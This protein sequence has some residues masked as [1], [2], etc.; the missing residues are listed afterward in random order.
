MPEVS[1]DI[2]S[3]LLTIVNACEH[4]DDSIRKNRLKIWRKHEQ[5]WHGLQHLFWNE[6]DNDWATPSAGVMAEF[7]DEYGEEGPVYD[8]VINICKA[9]GESIIGAVTQRLPFVHFPP[10][11][12]NKADDI[13]TAHEFSKIAE[14]I[15]KHNPVKLLF[16][17]AWY[18]LY[19]Q[20][21]V[22]GYNYSKSDKKYGTAR[23]PKYKSKEV[24][25]TPD[26]YFCRSCGTELG[27]DSKQTCP[28][29]GDSG[30]P[31]TREG[32]TETTPTLVGYDD[33]SKSRELLDVYGP[34]HCKLPEYARDQ[35]TCGYLLFYLEQ[36]YAELKELY[37]DIADKISKFTGTSDQYGRWARSPISEANIGDYSEE[38]GLLTV[39]RGWIRPW[40]Y[41]VL[42]KTS[43]IQPKELKKEFPIGCFVTFIGDIFA[44]AHEEN[45]DDH[46]T[47][48][49]AGASSHIHADPLIQPVIPIQEMKNTLVNLTIETIEHGIPEVWGSPEVVDFDVYSQ[50]EA[51]PGM[52]NKSKTSPSGSKNLGDYFFSM[53]KATLSREVPV[54]HAR[55][56]QEAQFALGSFP[57]IFGG[58]SEGKSRTFS[59][60]SMSRAMALQRLQNPWEMMSNWWARMMDKSVRSYASHMLT[61]EQFKKRSGTNYDSVFIKMVNLQ[62]S[63]G[64]V[65][66][67]ASEDLP[68]SSAQKR[69][70]ILK[71]V[72]FNNPYINAAIYH[73]ENTKNLADALSFVDFYIPGN[74][75]RIKQ[76]I[77][78]DKMVSSNEPL[79][80]DS[81]DD[82]AVHIQVLTAILISQVGLTLRDENPEAY[83]ACIIHINEHQ[84][85]LAAKTKGQHG[86]SV[87]GEAP[88]TAAP[89]NVG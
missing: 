43:K 46:W 29:C 18:I 38:S 81:I 51:K 87:P 65:E 61:D 35:A 7:G 14:L 48:S 42:D 69:D 20:G 76:R 45:L 26:R 3:A 85:A 4:E 33:I 88:D 44:D 53:P 36:H 52:L 83:Q 23:V 82:D 12:P 79:P 55:L 34:L 71:L 21:L 75:Q 78:F 1:L 25:A 77:E 30:V 11:N 6:R 60:Y 66:P 74:D 27:M 72:E 54:F 63:V 80:I 10:D 40:M 8:Y 73:P 84:Q 15:Q 24:K 9:H 67:E 70:L 22:C 56:D 58:P 49:V 47:I 68:V 62:G 13:T 57:S 2:Q 32:K 41:N 64:E 31:A 19:N 86:S 37:P 59:E 28:T 39:R 5:F 50:L 89:V 16:I 17:R